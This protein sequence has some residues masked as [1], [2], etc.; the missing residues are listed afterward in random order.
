MGSARRRKRTLTGIVALT[1]AIICL[2]LASLLPS[3]FVIRQPGPVVNTL[4]E[5]QDTDGN[6]VAL[7][8]MPAD[9][10]TFETSG[11]LSL[12]TVQIVGNRESTPNWFQLAQA[13]FD[14]S[15]A[16]VTIDS[17]FPPNQTSEQ[18]QEQDSLMMANSQHDATAAALIE[19]GYDVPIELQIGDV[20]EDGASAGKLE[21]GD[22]INGIN[23]T[24]MAS[25]LDMRAEIAKG[26][27]AD[28]TVNITRDGVTQDVVITPVKGDADGEVIWMIGVS[29]G[30]AYDF[31]FDVTIMLENIGGPS[32]GMIFA[33]GIIDTLTPG[34]MTGGESIAGTGT[35][36]YAGE[37]GPIGGIQQKMRGALSAGA[38]YFLAPQANCSEVVGHVPN[39]LTVVK[40]STLDE[41][42]DAVET[43]GVGNE[44]E[45]ASLPACSVK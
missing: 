43:I 44:V 3:G 7:I 20:Q 28:V 27:G 1:V 17:V 23:G 11:T 4:G 26:N 9:V 10:E 41:A 18:R 19:L 24:P 22:V 14:P 25:V 15:K 21:A 29:A 13:W 34:E 8:E 31:P 16:V 37:V 38:E 2:F 35:I 33:L 6:E 45:I 40:V 32:A 42:R 30:P 5:V 36:N 39:G 12:T